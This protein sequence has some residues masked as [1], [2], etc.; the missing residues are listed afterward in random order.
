MKVSGSELEMDLE[1][2]H[3]VPTMK[4]MANAVEGLAGKSVPL[5]KVRVWT[6][7]R[8]DPDTLQLLANDFREAL[9]KLKE[10]GEPGGR[11]GSW[12]VE[13]K[14]KPEDKKIAEAADVVT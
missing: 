1:S 7:D 4:H 11:F 10:G 12:M 2:G 14:F 8:K 13:K 5:D 6:L 9:R 3:Y